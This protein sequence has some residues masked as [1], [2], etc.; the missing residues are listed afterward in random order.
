MARLVN[1]MQ[2]CSLTCN[3]TAGCN[4]DGKD[5]CGAEPIVY[6]APTPYIN[7]VPNTKHPKQGTS[8]NLG[9]KDFSCQVSDKK[10]NGTANK[11]GKGNDS[12]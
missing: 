9:G 1:G 4:V 2:N 3:E 8:R 11:S 6:K 5:I 7:G 12:A 10:H